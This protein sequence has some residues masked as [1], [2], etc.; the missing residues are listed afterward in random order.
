VV[1]RRASFGRNVRRGHRA[2][3]EGGQGR[4]RPVVAALGRVALGARRG[5]PGRSGNKLVPVIIEACDR[6][7][8]FEL[9]HA[10]DLADWTGDTADSR[11]QTLVSDLRRLV[12]DED[13]AHRPH[14]LSSHRIGTGAGQPA[15]GPRGPQWSP[16]IA[17]PMKTN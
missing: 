12:G 11:W 13:R 8:I 2:G 5:D 16:Q 4:G 9:T 14:R 17:R 10:A 15:S 6:P 3:I 7:I 1:G